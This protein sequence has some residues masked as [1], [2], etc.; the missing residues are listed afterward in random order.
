MPWEVETISEVYVNIFTYIESLTI[1]GKVTYDASQN[2]QRTIID[3]SYDIMAGIS[4]FLNCLIF[5][6]AINVPVNLCLYEKKIK[7]SIGKRD[8]F[9]GPFLHFAS[10]AFLGL[11]VGTLSLHILILILVMWMMLANQMLTD[12]QDTSKCSPATAW[13]YSQSA[14]LKTETLQTELS[15]SG[16]SLWPPIMVSSTAN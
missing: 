1:F 15:H 3:P 2:S 10:S 9:T 14:M 16:C 7:C 13:G 11:W 5:L 4:L 6:T 8:P 12:R